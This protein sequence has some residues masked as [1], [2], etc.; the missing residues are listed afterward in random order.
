MYSQKIKNIGFDLDDVLLNFSDAIREHFNLKFNKNIQRKDIVA[1]DLEHSYGITKQ[2]ARQLID[3]FFFHED[4]HRA[5]PVEGAVEATK[6]LSEIFD[7]YIITA[8]PESLRD[9]T[10]LWIKKYF[11]DNF[12]DIH[13]ANHYGA[14]F[15]K[16]NKSDMCKELGIEVFIDDGLHNALDVAGSGIP[17]LLFDKPW[18][19]SDELPE[20]VTR[21][22]SWEEILQKLK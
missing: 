17:V 6:Q 21:V 12:K 14:Q 20:L 4:H 2:E 3:D 16:R 19:Q 18:N 10:E 7:L 5:L 9:H 1:F 11:E 22:H 15:V 8:K 13:F